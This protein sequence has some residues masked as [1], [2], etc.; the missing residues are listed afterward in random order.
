[1]GTKSKKSKKID[2]LEIPDAEKAK[3]IRE[4]KQSLRQT[5]VEAKLWNAFLQCETVTINGQSVLSSEDSLN[6]FLMS[7]TG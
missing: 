6:G 1:M 2:L 7:R 3:V 5:I 4:L